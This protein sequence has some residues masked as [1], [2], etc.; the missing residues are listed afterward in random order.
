LEEDQ[1]GLKWISSIA[2]HLLA[3]GS[4]GHTSAW[5]SVDFVKISSRMAIDISKQKESDDIIHMTQ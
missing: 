4:L 2:I 3:A 5:G 1:P